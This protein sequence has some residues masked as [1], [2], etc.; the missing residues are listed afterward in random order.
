MDNNEPN[1]QINERAIQWMIDCLKVTRQTS[2]A[3]MKNDLTAIE[4]CLEEEGRLAS[5]GSDLASARRSALAEPG[6]RSQHSMLRQSLSGMAAEIKSLNYRNA[7]LTENGLEF[8]RTLL[9]VIRPPATYG[10]SLTT[11]TPSYAAPT[12]SIISVKY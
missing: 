1:K 8:S 6:Y 5:Q 11:E 9:D 4:N 10:P 7:A 3:L 2:A 12:Q